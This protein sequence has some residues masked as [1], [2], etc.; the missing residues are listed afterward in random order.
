[1]ET[2]ANQG[3]KKEGATTTSSS[4]SGQ[5]WRRRCLACNLYFVKGVKFIRRESP[6]NLFLL[7]AITQLDDALSAR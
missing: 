6:I 4:L 1:M 7:P 3:G 5:Q 2:P